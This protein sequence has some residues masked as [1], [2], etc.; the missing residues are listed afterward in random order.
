LTII[1]RDWT[2]SHQRANIDDGNNA[3]IGISELWVDDTPDRAFIPRGTRFD[4]KLAGKHQQENAMVA[5]VALHAVHPHFPKL[6][7]RTIQEGLSHVEWPGRLQILDQGDNRPTILLDCAHNV[8]SAEKLAY[9]L[10]HDYRY[11]R[12]WLVLGITIDK[13]VTGILCTLL[14]LTDNVILTSSSHPRA[15]S[16]GKLKR[17]ATDLGFE[18]Q[19][20]PNI[21]EALITAWQGSNQKDLICVT[22]SIFIVGDLLNQWEGLQ[23]KLETVNDQLSEYG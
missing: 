17:I 12:L 16:P 21:A 22:G 14:P 15:T 6:T 8:D 2:Y 19:A 13:D 5:V 1:G 10:L 9:A 23:S 11:D 4:L 20:S 18:V 3:Y 7:L